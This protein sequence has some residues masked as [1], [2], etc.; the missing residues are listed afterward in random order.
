[1]RSP[2]L[3]AC[4]ALVASACT[5]EE[6][7][8]T[9][10]SILVDENQDPFGSATSIDVQVFY[11]DGSDPVR[12]D[13]DPLTGEHRLEGLRE[14]TGVIVDIIA[15]DAGGS[16]V[17]MGR[18]QP[19]DV[20][21]AGDEASVFVGEVDSLAR[22]PEGLVASRAWAQG[23]YTPGGRVVVVGGGDN[24]E[25]PVEDLEFV[26]WDVMAP[27]HGVEGAAFPRMGHQITH[28]PAALGGPFAGQV[29]SFGGA[30]GG[31]QDTLEGAWQ[32]A[33][34][35]I[36]SIDPVGG[37][38]ND[39]VGTLDVPMAL[40]ELAWTEDDR[41]ALIGGYT[42]TGQYQEAIRLIDPTDLDE[43]AIGPAIE[44]RE[45]HRVSELSVA[46][47]R[48]LLISGGTTAATGPKDSL[49]LW[50][51]DPEVP[52]DELDGIVMT[53]PR[54]R[55]TST[56]MSTGR[57]LLAGGSIGDPGE[58]FS[59]YDRGISTNSADVFDPVFRSITP[60]GTPM[61]LPRQ[62][63]VAAPIADDLVLVCGG[64]D[65]EGNALRSCE[66]YDDSGLGS[67]RPFTGGAMSPGG[68]GVT[69]VPFPDGRVLFLGGAGTGGPDDSVYLYTPTT[70][71]SP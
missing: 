57:V 46:G 45:Q 20:G 65:S 31:G 32:L 15:R 58:N 63:H 41:I 56:A 14:G 25:S 60:T 6:A 17:A 7:F 40:F 55:H 53:E 34:D 1:M 11:A 2:V 39:G 35:T 3:L 26:G 19:F 49:D 59:E 27:L 33:D 52:V 54:L 24:E 48:L 68:P 71:G 66:I 21:P 16:P 62:R 22:V 8:E 69:A 50:E 30:D 36:A 51:L 18:S 4:L 9:P 42:P 64:E 12:G 23:A 43:Q 47:N 5:P 70:L 38:L 10:L 61:V 28:V 37:G 13:I 29:L 44:T 67:W